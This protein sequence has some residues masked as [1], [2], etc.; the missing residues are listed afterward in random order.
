MNDFDYGR[1]F[2]E[3]EQHMIDDDMARRG[4]GRPTGSAQALAEA[5]LEAKAGASG[6]F[7]SAEQMRRTGIMAEWIIARLPF[8]GL[9]LVERDDGLTDEAREAAY[10]KWLRRGR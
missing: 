1:R 7:D 2:R 5:M 3:I 8:H 6:A 4:V 10:R 9:A